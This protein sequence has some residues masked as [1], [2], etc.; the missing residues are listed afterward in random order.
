MI[1]YI[2]TASKSHFLLLNVQMDVDFQSSSV[3]RNANKFKL[4]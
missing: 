1:E 4:I 2:S 3:V